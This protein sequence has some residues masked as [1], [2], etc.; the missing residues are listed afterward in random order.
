MTN[1]EL[2][3]KL[4][5][6]GLLRTGRIV[7]AFRAVYRQDFVPPGLADLAYRDEPLPIG[8]GQ[9]ISQPLTVAF[10]LEALAPAPGD[11]ILDIGAGSGWQAALLASIVSAREGKGNVLAIERVPEL[12][13]MAEANVGKYSFIESGIVRVILG[14]AS[15]GA[16]QGFIPTGGFDKIIA[17]ASTLEIPEAWKRQ[18][19][20]GGRIVAPILQSIVVLDKMSENEFRRKEHSGFSFVPLVSDAEK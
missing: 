1:E 8:H 9:T 12:R 11:R 5:R 2:V 16:P 7:Q 6:Q 17:A 10:M 18:V 14:D 15:A 13:A 4:I 3:R 19:K 20:I